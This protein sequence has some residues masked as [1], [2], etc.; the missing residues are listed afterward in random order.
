MIPSIK[1]NKR[2]DIFEIVFSLLVA[3]N[4]EYRQ[5]HENDLKLLHNSELTTNVKLFI[6][7]YSQL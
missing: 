2:Q 7:Q 3:G 4:V 5:L 6:T 1:S